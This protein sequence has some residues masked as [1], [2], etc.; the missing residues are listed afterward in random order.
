MGSK[1]V[2][3]EASVSVTLF[4]LRAWGTITMSIMMLAKGVRRSSVCRVCRASTFP[5]GQDWGGVTRFSMQAIF[6]Q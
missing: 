6:F 3:V 4:F 1:E 2:N 5:P